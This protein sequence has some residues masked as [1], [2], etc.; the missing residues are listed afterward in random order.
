VRAHLIDS[1]AGEELEQR[2]R[3]GGCKQL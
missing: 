2:G 3:T 1:V